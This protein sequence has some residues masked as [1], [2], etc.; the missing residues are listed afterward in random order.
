MIQTL[1]LS[2]FTNAFRNSDRADQFSY[3]AQVILF[4]Y[5]EALEDDTG[6]QIVFDMIGICCEWAEDTPEEIATA[7]DIDICVSPENTMQNVL[8]YL[9]DHTQVAGV[10]DAGTIV[11]CSSF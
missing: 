6:E 3:E 4:D 10:T 7:Y 5:F 1:R 8:E 9:N 11:Y 2:D